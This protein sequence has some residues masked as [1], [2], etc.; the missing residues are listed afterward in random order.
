[1]TLAVKADGALDQTD[2]YD[3][4]AQVSDSEVVFFHVLYGDVQIFVW[5]VDSEVEQA[6]SVFVERVGSQGSNNCNYSNQYE[7]SI[8]R[9]NLPAVT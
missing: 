7:L 1:M 5:L 8:E 3:K 2:E 9:A 6:W 4:N